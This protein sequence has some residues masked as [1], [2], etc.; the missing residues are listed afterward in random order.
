MPYLSGL[1]KL[2]MLKKVP[3]LEALKATL[4]WPLQQRLDA[5]APTHY[6][7][8][9]G[10]R[11]PLDYTT[12]ETPV[13]PV[14]LQQMF[15]TT[16]HPTLAGGKVPLIVHLLSPAGRP[17]QITQDLPGFWTNSYPAVKAEM[18]GRYPKPPWPDDPV[19][20][21][22]TRRAKPRGT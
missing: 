11:V 3:L 17:L 13:L 12:G 18:K 1:S 6:R 14:R 20:A 8:P 19:A 16:D 22:P 7:V 9:T 5:E 10:D 15:G 2:S 21:E 4:P